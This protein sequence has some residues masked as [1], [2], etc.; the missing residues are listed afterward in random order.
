MFPLSKI[1]E[2]MECGRQD[3][4]TCTQERRGEQL[5][6]C[7]KRSVLYEN[8]CRVCNPGMGGEEREKL[9][10][11]LDIPSIYVGESGRSLY[12]RGKEH[13]RAFRNKEDDSHIL[14]HHVIHHGGVGEPSFHLR[15][16]RFLK[17]AL[18]RQISEAVRIANWG[19]ERIINSKGEYNRCK[20]G[21][22]T[23]GEEMKK[24]IKDSIVVGE[25][26]Y[27]SK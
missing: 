12:E 2:R 9:T 5:P 4:I 11:P 27:S 26:E 14:K 16:I 23:L 18:T 1:G 24:S 7:T 13:W 17:T 6:P 15:P 10:P 8:I 19:E 20:V 3:C 25:D 21:R 22:L